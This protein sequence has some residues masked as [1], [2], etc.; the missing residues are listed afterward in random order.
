MLIYYNIY[1]FISFNF[2]SKLC[3]ESKE[4]VIRHNAVERSRVKEYCRKK[5]VTEI[6]STHK[7][8]TKW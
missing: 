6:R 2:S 1:S 4:K 7:E 5:N 3:K 8:T